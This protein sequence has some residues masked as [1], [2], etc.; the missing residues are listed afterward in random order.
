MG[1]RL[2]AGVACQRASARSSCA[3]TT[4]HLEAARGGML[5]RLT[6]LQQR[7][8]RFISRPTLPGSFVL[9]SKHLRCAR[10][11]QQ[12]DRLPHPEHHQAAA[13]RPLQLGIS[14][15]LFAACRLGKHHAG[16]GIGAGAGLA[17]PAEGADER[18]I[19]CELLPMP[20]GQPVADNL[21][22]PC[23]L[24]HRGSCRPAARFW[25]HVRQP[26]D[27][28]WR[29][30]AEEGWRA[31]QGQQWH[32]PSG[33]R[34]VHPATFGRRRSAAPAGAADATGEGG[35]PGSAHWGA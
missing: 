31:R 2:W 3:S 26:R 22:P 28:A 7:G 20:Q 1:R 16:A 33:G 11:R 5:R 10:S 35:G 6:A 24:H 32:T 21:N 4:P 8:C 27:T 9:R 30:L 14:L 23:V 19:N 25:P 29:G 15:A 12:A 34:P 13:A 17:V 18:G